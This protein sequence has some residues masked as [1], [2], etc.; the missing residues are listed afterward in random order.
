MQED[1]SEIETMVGLL[2][3]ELSNFH[4]AISQNDFHEENYINFKRTVKPVRLTASFS[5]LGSI[6]DI[7]ANE[8]IVCKF[9]P[10]MFKFFGKT[11]D[12]SKSVDYLDNI[13]S[14]YMPGKSLSPDLLK[15]LLNRITG[16]DNKIYNFINTVDSDI[17]NLMDHESY[18]KLFCESVKP[19]AR[20]MTDYKR[21]VA[22]DSS[23][24]YSRRGIPQEVRNLISAENAKNFFSHWGV[25]NQDIFKT[26]LT[27]EIESLKSEVPID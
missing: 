9:E 19:N 27:K 11:K 16:R 17:R 3:G 12:I 21:A 26:D 10:E 14:A 23:I 18:L 8:Y 22:L 1:I 7:T 15:P 25:L 5:S 13:I 20:L 2:V 6:G 24:S 4:D